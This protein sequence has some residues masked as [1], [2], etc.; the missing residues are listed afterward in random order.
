[1]VSIYFP[2]FLTGGGVIFKGPPKAEENF[3][4][5]HSFVYGGV[6]QV[7]FRDCACTYDSLTSSSENIFPNGFCVSKDRVLGFTTH[8]VRA[9]NSS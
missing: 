5:P 2:C 6:V 9:S 1:M 7:D 8:V 3:G 4:S